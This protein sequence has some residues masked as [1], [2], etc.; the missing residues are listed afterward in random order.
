MLETVDFFENQIKECNAHADRALNKADREFW[1][2]LA[3]RWQQVL[4]AEKQSSPT[5]Q[6]VRNLRPT[7]GRFSKRQAA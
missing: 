4:R 5:F 2:R 1:K 6:T 7:R 3:E